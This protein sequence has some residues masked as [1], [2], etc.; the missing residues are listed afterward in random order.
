MISDARRRKNGD[1][2]PD[3]DPDADE[4]LEDGRR[5]R[6]RMEMMDK[7]RPIKW[8]GPLDARQPDAWLV[9]D[10]NPRAARQEMI[11]R[12]TNAWRSP[13][14]VPNQNTAP[15]PASLRDAQAVRRLAYDQYCNRIQNAWKTP[16][17]NHDGRIY[18][19]INPRDAAPNMTF[20]ATTPEQFAAAYNR[21]RDQSPE[22]MRAA[23]YEERN[24]L[25]REA[26]K[27]P[28]NPAAAANQVER[29]AEQWR[30]GR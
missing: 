9:R 4:V 14:G 7:K 8:I 24:R 18:S 30:H 11:D 28:S 6:V 12:A 22:A 29:Q 26:W 1:D 16:P 3:G 17:V 20:R 23:A 5:V 19:S 10:A 2:D 25:Q 27:T 21:G 15:R 13:S